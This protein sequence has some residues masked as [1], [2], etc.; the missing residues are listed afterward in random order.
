MYL[1]DVME[2]GT[3]ETRL[4]LVCGPPELALSS[5][6]EM[7]DGDI[8]AYLLFG[9]RLDDLDSAQVGLLEERTVDVARQFAASRIEAEVSKRLGVDLVRIH[10]GGR[11]TTLTLG[12]YLSPRALVKLEQALGGD[13]V[14]HPYEGDV[15]EDGEFEI[16][17]AGQ[18][19]GYFAGEYHWTPQ[20]PLFALF[21]GAM[22]M[23]LSME[24][25][26]GWFY[27]G[28]GEQWWNELGARFDI[29]AFAADTLGYQSAGWF[30]EEEL[31]AAE[32]ERLAAEEQA[33]AGEEMA[34]Q[35]GS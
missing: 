26:M 23:G 24:E 12:K 1:D 13:V 17:L 8:L 25:Y 11:R 21:G 3:L 34:I 31:R 18:A 19:D 4:Y 2:H 20:H 7:P 27:H 9:R 6:P 30:T 5:D 22:P 10:G 28:N 32:L 29:R 14:F 16:A 35:G 33:E 15:P